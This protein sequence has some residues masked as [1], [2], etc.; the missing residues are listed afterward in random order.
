VEE[1]DNDNDD[2]DMHDDDNDSSEYNRFAPPGGDGDYFAEDDQDG[3][4]FG[5]G[6]NSTQKQIL[7]IFDEGDDLNTDTPQK[8]SIQSV[9]RQLLNLERTIN[10]NSEMRIKWSGQPDKWVYLTTK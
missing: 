10:K 3:R 6:L 8:T 7:D 2:E 1:D 4:F 5:G 9:R